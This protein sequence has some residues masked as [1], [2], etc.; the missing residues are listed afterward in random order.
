[1]D[2]KSKVMVIAIIVMIVVIIGLVTYIVVYK[3]KT[4]MRPS[5]PEIDE[6]NAVLIEDNENNDIENNKFENGVSINFVKTIT[7]DSSTG[8]AELLF[9]LPDS[10]DLDSVIS[11]MIN[12]ETI[13]RSGRIKSGYQ[14]NELNLLY[15][16]KSIKKGSYDGT[17]M[18]SFYAKDSNTEALVGTEIPVTVIVK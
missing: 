2:K 8:K 9:A 3:N 10:K 17:L 18:I 1:M 14:V 4:E 16:N 7:I 13:I 15:P 11:I 6:S 12:S 5:G